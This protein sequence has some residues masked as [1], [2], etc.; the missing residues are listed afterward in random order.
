[1][2]RWLPQTLFIDIHASHSIE[3]FLPIYILFEGTHA[4]H[5]HFFLG[6]ETPVAAADIL[7][8]E[9]GKLYAVE[10]DHT[11]AEMLE[12]TTHDAVLAAVNLD[13]YLTLVGFAG[14]IDSIGMDF[15]VVEGDALSNLLEVAGSHL[16]VEID[17]VDLLLEEL[18]MGE[19]AGQVAIIGEQEHTCGV[20]VQTAHRIDTLGA[21]ALHQIHHCLT[22]LGVVAGGNVILRFVEQHINFLLECNR[23][24]VEH[25]AIGAQDLCSQLGHN[26]AIDLHD[27]CRDELIGL[28]T[29]AN[30]GVSQE[31]VQAKGLIGIV[32]LLLILNA[33]LH[34]ILRIGIVRL[35]RRFLVG[36]I[37]VI[38]TIVI[39][40]T[41]LTGLSVTATLL[42]IATL[43]LLIATTLL[44]VATLTWL[45]ALLLSFH[46]IITRTITLLRTLL[47]ATT[48]LAIAT[49]TLLVATL[50]A[51]TTLIAII[52]AGAIGA[53]LRLKSGA[54]SFGAEA[55]LV[56]VIHF[57]VVRTLSVDTRTG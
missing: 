35:A 12:D 11:I 23:L 9:S 28:T 46:I 22:L 17:M 4:E 2:S 16:L 30:T 8:G 51:I 13:A 19:F 7:L 47:V 37:V 15:S 3:F 42:A 54:E 36:V 27:T 53:L 6:E 20:A 43:A 14:I 29:A 39:I 31:L 38:T 33:L 26:L 10:L 41:G 25:H 5:F 40:R 52:V 32:I 45:V 57:V 48:L 49:L 44:A 24:V 34:A 21:G 50:L 56:V 1:M 55:A 18:G